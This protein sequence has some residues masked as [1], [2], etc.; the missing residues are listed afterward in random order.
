MEGSDICLCWN[1][2][3]INDEFGNIVKAAYKSLQVNMSA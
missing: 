2:N 1:N 3:K